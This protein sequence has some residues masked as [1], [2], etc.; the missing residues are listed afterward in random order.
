[1]G[2]NVMCRDC[3]S[4]GRKTF[5]DGRIEEFCWRTGRLIRNGCMEFQYNRRKPNTYRR[6]KRTKKHSA[7]RLQAGRVL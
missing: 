3:K 7:V 5:P 1:M 4:Y 2:A 6:K